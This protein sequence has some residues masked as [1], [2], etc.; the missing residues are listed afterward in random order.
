[1]KTNIRELKINQV[2]EKQLKKKGFTYICEATRRCIVQK[3]AKHIP[4]D[5]FIHFPFLA[6]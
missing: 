4:A 3:M 6:E 1:M 5:A 2:K